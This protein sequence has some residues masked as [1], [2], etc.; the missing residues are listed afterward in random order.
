MK[1]AI[2]GG[3][4]GM[5]SAIVSALLARGHNVRL[6]SLRAAR[7]AKAWAAGVEA[8]EA[9]ITEPEALAGCSDGCE[10]VLHLGVDAGADAE[11]TSAF[12][13]SL[14]A[15][16]DEA[17]R[18]GARRFVYACPSD[19]GLDSAAPAAPAAMEE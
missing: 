6:V 11:E 9:D 17:A 3:T 16:V 5:T 15:L 10:A 2:V 8:F 14:Q 18:A 4:P 13:Q 7:E 12:M 19:E 1:V